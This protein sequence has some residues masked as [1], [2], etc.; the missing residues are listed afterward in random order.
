M[1][2]ASRIAGNAS[3]EV[4]AGYEDLVSRFFLRD[5]KPHGF[6]ATVGTRLSI[7]EVSIV[8]KAEEP[9]REEGRFVCSLEVTEDMLNG[10]GSM[11][12]GCSAFLIDFCSSLCL[13]AH[14]AHVYG[15]PIFMVSQALNIVYH[16][17]ASLGDK[18]R[19]VNTTLT[20]GARASSARSEIWNDTHH[21]LVA[22]G[23][24]IKMQPSV[25]PKNKL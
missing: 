4:K 24:H 14:S 9:T 13:S 19:I 3:P 20:M 5:G 11:H 22:S 18:I 12:G 25:P 2:K 21:R 8:K 7:D 6:A 1:A 16:S 17:P 15:A 10:A 23:V